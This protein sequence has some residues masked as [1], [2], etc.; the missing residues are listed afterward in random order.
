MHEWPNAPTPD[1]ARVL[2]QEV[3]RAGGALE[4]PL[5]Q[6]GSRFGVQRLTQSSR[7]RMAEDLRRVG[8]V[9]EPGIAEAQRTEIIRLALPTRRWTVAPTHSEQLTGAPSRPA[10]GDGAPRI[11]AGTPAPVGRPDARAAAPSRRPR[12]DRWKAAGA[13]AIVLLLIAVITG[14]SDEGAPD[15]T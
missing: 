14:G 7:A 8:L 9:A 3:A 2:S 12:S 1:P 10:A 15:G 4:L 6:I 11:F 5:S 13:I